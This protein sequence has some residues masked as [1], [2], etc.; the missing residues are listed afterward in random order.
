MVRIGLDQCSGRDLHQVRFERGVEL[1]QVLIEVGCVT[2]IQ[3]DING[4]WP[5]FTVFAHG[6]DGAVVGF[7]VDK[8]MR[9]DDK[10]YLQV[11]SKEFFAFFDAT[12]V[13]AA[14]VLDA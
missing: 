10:R 2:A 3:L 11:T 5:N 6:A 12:L 9:A 14:S 1:P 4:Q 8:R 7:T 13:P